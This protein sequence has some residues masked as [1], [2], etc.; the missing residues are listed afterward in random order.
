MTFKKVVLFTCQD[1][2]YDE[3]HEKK[4]S[5]RLKI[6]SFKDMDLQFEV[7]NLGQGWNDE[8]FWKDIRLIFDPTATISKSLSEVVFELQKPAKI[9]REVQLEI[10]E[11]AK[12]KVSIYNIIRFD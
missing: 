12:I 1:N 7:V 8:R 5:I 3:D 11:G 4:H 10:T 6:N 9:Y 2:P